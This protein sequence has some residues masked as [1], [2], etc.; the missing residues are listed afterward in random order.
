[1]DRNQLGHGLPTA[2]GYVTAP[3]YARAAPTPPL[4]G[5]PPD[6]RDPRT[7][8]FGGG[9]HH[10]TTLRP[11]TAPAY[12]RA[13]PGLRSPL[14]R[15]CRKRSGLPASA[16]LRQATRIEC[17]LFGRSTAEMF[18]LASGTRRRLH[19]RHSHHSMRSAIHLFGTPCSMAGSR[20]S[21]RT[22]LHPVFRPFN[23][24]II[25]ALRLDATRLSR[26]LLEA[27]CRANR[28]AQT[29]GLSMNT[30]VAIGSRPDDIGY[31]H[32]DRPSAFLRSRSGR[33]ATVSTRPTQTALRHP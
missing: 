5:A 30:T 23:T 19:S 33:T 21:V 9:A 8:R 31:A 32:A 20:V 26:H 4:I 29:F 22:S 18:L 12:A 14:L 1:M 15:R 13:A 11:V 3:A 7:N 28:S 10:I 2:P 6:G 24:A 27:R 17:R 16:S 25:T